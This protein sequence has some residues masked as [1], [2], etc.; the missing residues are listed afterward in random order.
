MSCKQNKMRLSS[1]SR[2]DGYFSYVLTRDSE[3]QET[4]LLS[5]DSQRAQSCSP[6]LLTATPT[7]KAWSQQC[8]TPHHQFRPLAHQQ[9]ATV[10]LLH[11][12]YKFVSNNYSYGTKNNNNHSYVYYF[13]IDCSVGKR[14]EAATT[15]VPR[16]RSQRT[17]SQRVD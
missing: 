5:V 8:K 13:G 3:V 9:H 11:P 14:A 16:H 7:P 10:K 12:H 4:T 2:R 17:S 15:S 6:Y 1:A